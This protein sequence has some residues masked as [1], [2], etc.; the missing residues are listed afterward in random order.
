[1]YLLCAGTIKWVHT[2]CLNNW[3]LA[4]RQSSG[5]QQAIRCEM[6]R[7]QYRVGPCIH[8]HL[9]LLYNRLD[10]LRPLCGGPQENAL[11]FN[12]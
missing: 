6:C 2:A 8:I 3:C 4:Q 1:V 10:W 12:A 11:L 5:R 9:Q 7:A